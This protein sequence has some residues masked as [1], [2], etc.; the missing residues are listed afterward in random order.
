MEEI[1]NQLVFLLGSFLSGVL[2]MLAYEAV[3]VF[4]GLFRPGVFIKLVLDVLFFV[5]SGVCVFQ[6]IFLCNNGTIRSFFVFAFGAGAVLYRKTVGT[7]LSD[8]T[9]KIVRKLWHL[10][11][12][13]FALLVKKVRTKHKLTQKDKKGLEKN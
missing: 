4:R 10:A 3:N 13:P 8:L 11:S 5:I 7:L 2:V 12:R 1:K 6:M 9:V